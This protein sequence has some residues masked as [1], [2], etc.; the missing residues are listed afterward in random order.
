M[1]PLGTPRGR[2]VLFTFLYF[3][4]GAPIGFIWWALP[5][6]LRSQGV[7]VE[8][9]TLLTS[10]LVLPWMFKFLWAPLIDLTRLQQ[11]TL[12]SWIVT[13]QGVM[14]V[15]LL[16]LFLLDSWH[17]IFS[18]YPFLLIHAIA[19]A[20][21]DAA[22][23]ALAIATVPEQER[24]SLNGWMQVGMLAGRS[25]LGGGAEANADCLSTLRT[26]RNARSCHPPG[27]RPG[28]PTT[29]GDQISHP[30]TSILLPPFSQSRRTDPRHQ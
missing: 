28:V 2:T 17:A 4:E 1:N 14:G 13:M 9:I 27:W 22:I 23:D 6:T 29:A 30:T 3:S 20:T 18:V 21:Q 8:Y 26:D 11:W 16:P 19:A 12:R 25:L 7:S 24:G 15:S 10:T 5:T